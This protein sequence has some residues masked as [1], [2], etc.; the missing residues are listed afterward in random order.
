M[1]GSVR[2]LTASAGS[3]ALVVPEHVDTVLAS[4]L[5][6]LAIRR[7]GAA[8]V[9]IR[10]RIPFAGVDLA[11]AWLLARTLFSGAARR[12][13][14]EFAE[15]VRRVGGSLT[16]DVDADRLRIVGRSL[17]SG[18]DRLLAATAQALEAAEYPPQ[19]VLAARERSA[20]ELSAA[21]SDPGRLA[22]IVLARRIYDGHPYRL[23]LPDP[24][25]VRQVA[26]ED[27][28]AVHERFVRPAGSALVMV[29]DLD[30]EAMAET[31]ARRLAGWRGAADDGPP[32]PVPAL[33]PG[34]L[35]LVD[36]PGSEQSLLR[37][38]LP[39]V[40]RGHPDNAALRLA[41]LVFGGYFCSRWT[42]NL[43]DDKGYT[44]APRSAIEE[45]AAG[46]RLIA[47][48][49]VAT[50]AT[51][52]ALAETVYELGKLACLP[53]ERAEVDRARRYTVGSLAV[54][55]MSTHRA[56]AD[57]ALGLLGAGLPLAYLGTYVEQLAAATVEDVHQAANT[58]LAPSGAVAVILGDAARVERSVRAL[59]AVTLAGP[60]PVWT[61][62]DV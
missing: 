28:R 45:S 7:P 43:R 1:S 29:G 37:L 61:S 25:R 9:E 56:L 44:Y 4:G 17:E 10:L 15:T 14:Q 30:P 8:L 34:P 32:P 36:R 48:A 51:A 33:R 23:H 35:L 6:V 21:P 53:P 41:N 22:G 24:A 12:P 59:T 50:A 18:L 27:L 60:S 31:A 26:P 62:I 46:A 20:R 3:R 39:A 58:Y 11:R 5:R 57:L 2:S 16:A 38:A 19:A 47:T 40:R 49:D 54:L 13:A 52:P 42:A 55:A